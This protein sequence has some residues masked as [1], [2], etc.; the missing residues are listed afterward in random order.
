[1]QCKATLLRNI[2]PTSSLSDPRAS[3]FLPNEA[4]VKDENFRT[5]YKKKGRPM[6][7]DYAEREMESGERVVCDNADWVALVPFWAM[8]PFETMLLPKTRH[9]KHMSVLDTG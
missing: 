9:V 7:L 6:L 3:S 1:M 8:W 4:S 5:Y 2:K